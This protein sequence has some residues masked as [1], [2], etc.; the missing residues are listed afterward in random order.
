MQTTK[1][2]TAKVISAFQR[3]CMQRVD[4]GKEY[5]SITGCLSTVADT[6][7][8]SACSIHALD[9]GKIRTSQRRARG[10]SL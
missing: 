4:L 3:I 9:A 1:E 7:A 10:G 5:L 2:F 8:C 6:T